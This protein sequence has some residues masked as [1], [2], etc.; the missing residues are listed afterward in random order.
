MKNQ[1]L[2][3]IFMIVLEIIMISLISSWM[4][5]TTDL[6]E[7]QDSAS[8]LEKISSFGNINDLMVVVVL[9]F[10]IIML[11]YR[12]Y[13]LSTMGYILLIVS[14]CVP[15]SII[16]N[17]FWYQVSIRDVRVYRIDLSIF[18]ESMFATLT[19]MICFRALLGKVTPFLLFLVS[20]FEIF[21]YSL[22]VYVSSFELEIFDLGKS[23]N[24]HLFAG[25]FSITVSLIYTMS[26]K[27]I[28]TAY[29][30]QVS[31]HISETIT[32]LGTFLL[33]IYLPGANGS[34]AQNT[35]FYRSIINSVMSLISSTVVT[36]LLS[37]F[38]NNGKFTIKDVRNGTIVG[39]IAI[40][41]VAHLYLTPIVSM[42]IGG[43]ASLISFFS[44]NM[45][46]GWYEKRLNI[47]DTS[48]I[49]SLNIIP[50]FV[51]GLSSIIVSA[52]ASKYDSKYSDQFFKYFPQGNDQWKFQAGGLFFTIGIA[53][54][55]GGFCGLC[56]KLFNFPAPKEPFNDEENWNESNSTLKERDDSDLELKRQN[57]NISARDNFN[58]KLKTP[59]QSEDDDEKIS[60]D[61]D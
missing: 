41:S 10:G 39:G 52:I 3:V 55:G 29:K 44:M 15:F 54:F 36:F 50:G 11:S 1:K 60:S 43:V 14:F 27:A 18:I 32:L 25:C 31:D 12:N 53:I 4:R 8:D 45:F 40:G 42:G 37:G 7:D 16:L 22:N 26:N 57:F 28:Y 19:V 61:S 34:L 49:F 56:I 38:F 6:E 51:S 48:E 5:Y 9:G 17:V 23:M 13:G 2:L 24:V 47:K 58:F 59:M 30:K 35:G 20:I 33:W 21:F 46:C